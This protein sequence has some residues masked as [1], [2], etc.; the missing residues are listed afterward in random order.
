MIETTHESKLKKRS[1]VELP[2]ANAQKYAHKSAAE[3]L[4]LFHIN[5]NTF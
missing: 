3:M 2:L 1:F 5:E 4:V